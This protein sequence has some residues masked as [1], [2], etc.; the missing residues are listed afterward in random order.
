LE[1]ASENRTTSRFERLEFLGDAVIDYLVTCHLFAR[2]AKIT[3]DTP[4]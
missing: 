1:E 2:L 3:E 4:R